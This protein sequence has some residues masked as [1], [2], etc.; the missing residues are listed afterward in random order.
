[1]LMLP[2]NLAQKNGHTNPIQSKPQKLE[3]CN[4][5]REQQIWAWYLQ[6]KIKAIQLLL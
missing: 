5:A 4:S 3:N 1:M 6:D 2:A